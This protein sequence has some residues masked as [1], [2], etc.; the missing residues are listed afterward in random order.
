MVKEQSELAMMGKFSN[1]SSE[2]QAGGM[3]RAHEVSA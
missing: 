1:A 2:H 3:K